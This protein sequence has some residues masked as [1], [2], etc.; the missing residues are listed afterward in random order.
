MIWRFTI[1]FS[2]I[3]VSIMLFCI[4]LMCHPAWANDYEQQVNSKT[5]I[6]VGDNTY[7]P[8][9][10][11]NN[12]GQQEGYDIDFMSLLEKESGSRFSISLMEWYNAKQDIA[13]GRA[14]ILIGV[15]KTPERSNFLDFTEPYLETRTVIFVSKENFA[16]KELEDLKNYRVG[17]QKGD[18]GENLITG[19]STP[20]QYTNQKSALLALAEGRVDAVAGNYFTGM[21]W[22]NT[23][24]WQEE[25]KVVGRPLAV[26]EYCLGVKKGEA[27]LLLTL[28]KS[29]QSLKDKGQ[30]AQ[31]QDKWFGENY[32]SNS[33][34]YSR[35]FWEFVSWFL[36]AVVAVIGVGILFV[37]SLR[38]KV[39]LAT[40]QLRE[41]NQ[42]LA[43]AY[44]ITIRAFFNALE[45]RESGTARHSFVVNS[46]SLE[47]GREMKLSETELLHLTWGTLLHDIGKLAISDE[48]LLKKGKLTDEEYE[49]IKRHPQIG[50]DIL[51][52]A[53]YLQEAAQITLYHQERYDGKGYPHGLAGENIPLLARICTVADAFEA[54]VANRPYRKG[55]HWREA[56][57]EI[58]KHSGSQ[59]DP[60]IVA[61]FIK[62]DHEKMMES[63]GRE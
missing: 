1:V 7:P 45:K 16:I 35:R 32:F 23:Y 28:N 19:Y 61:I 56:L 8:L 42:Q 15:V 21:Y 38:R 36:L 3:K 55:L 33:F 2:I 43:G 48:I 62:L 5:Y 53:D 26:N 4:S 39:Q 14:D 22:I 30:L 57:E 51:Q 29:I 54:M 59:F 20:I 37:Y 40:K 6:A 25:I 11:I 52:G 13:V 24:N 46:I 17:V 27:E 60:H 63:C 10:Y 50:Y 9:I 41:A 58:I 47:I 44:E 34:L 49:D 12:K 31:L 18:M